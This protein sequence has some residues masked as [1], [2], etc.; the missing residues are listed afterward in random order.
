MRNTP[1]TARMKET[2]FLLLAVVVCGG[3]VAPGPPPMEILMLV[4]PGRFQKYSL[5]FLAIEI[6]FGARRM[7][8]WRSAVNDGWSVADFRKL[9]KKWKCENCCRS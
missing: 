2:L 3:V 7:S 5:T 1:K 8:Y 9:G 4:V 6:V